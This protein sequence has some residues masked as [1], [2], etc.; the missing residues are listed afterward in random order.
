VG[1]VSAP[2]G[3]LGAFLLG[4]LLLPIVGSF[5]IDGIVLYF[6]GRSP[7][8]LFVASALTVATVVLYWFAWQNG[9]TDSDAG[10]TNQ[11]GSAVG[12]ILCFSVPAALVGFG[13]RMAALFLNPSTRQRDRELIAARA[14]RRALHRAA[15]PSLAGR[16]DSIAPPVIEQAEGE[17]STV[18]APPVARARHAA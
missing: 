10:T 16:D 14:S 18:A 8:L 13:L 12:L 1:D 7:R 11:I 4:G 17:P 3:F 6:R 9:N 15:A 2:G 5:V